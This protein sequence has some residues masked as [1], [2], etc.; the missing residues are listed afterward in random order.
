MDEGYNIYISQA[1]DNE[2]IVMKLPTNPE[3]IEFKYDINNKKY[4]VL[5]IGD[6]IRMGTKGLK[7]FTVKSF[8]PADENPDIAIYTIEKMISNMII[9]ETPL[10]FKINKI[11][12]NRF[13]VDINIDVVVDSFRYGEKGGE[14]GDIDYTLEMT[15]HREHKAKVI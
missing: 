13:I 15:E 9:Y 8:F 14:V 12:S 5:G 10:N 4:N 2:V 11:Q 6:V 1:T 3:E 7:D